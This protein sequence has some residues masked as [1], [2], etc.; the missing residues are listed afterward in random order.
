MNEHPGHSVET[1]KFCFPVKLPLDPLPLFRQS[2]GGFYPVLFRHAVS[3][4]LGNCR[5]LGITFVNILIDFILVLAE[6]EK[7]GFDRLPWYI[8]KQIQQVRERQADLRHHYQLPNRQVRSGDVCPTVAYSVR[9][10]DY[11]RVL[12]H[13]FPRFPRLVPEGLSQ[14]LR[15]YC[16]H[17][18][19]LLKCLSLIGVGMMT[20]FH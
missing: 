2:V 10:C 12:S 5:T 3:I 11:F 6:I 9:L 13:R 18:P 19:T 4:S 14:F 7:G 17:I 15:D 16:R 1:H 8:R 20:E